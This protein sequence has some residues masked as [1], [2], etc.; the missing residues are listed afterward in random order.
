MKRIL[1]M[2]LTLCL[3]LSIAPV[4]FAEGDYYNKEGY[5]ICDEEITVT[6]AG[7]FGLKVIPEDIIAWQQWRERFGLK[8]DMTFYSGEDWKTQLN[9][10]FASDEL[11][12]ILCDAGLSNAEMTDGVLR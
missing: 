10:M 7:S 11:P 2:A 9:L 4:V 1:A 3:V 6:T 12:D 5:R 8:F